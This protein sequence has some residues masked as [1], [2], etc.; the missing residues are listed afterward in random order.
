MHR[1]IKPANLLFDEEGRVRVADFG[2]ARALAEA[3]WTEPAGA[4]VGTARYISPEAAEGK[5]VDGR[6]DV[7]SLALVLY[8]AVT[9]T[10]PFVT[11]TTMGTLAARIGQP[12]PHD[13]ALGPLDDV[14]ARAAA[15]AAAA[16][17]D[18]S[19]LGARLGALA[20]ALPTAAP[21]PLIIGNHD[22]SSPIA[23]FRAP[24]VSELTEVVPV[25]GA[26]AGAAAGAAGGAHGTMVSGT[27]PEAGPRA[28]PGA[29]TGAGAVGG[30]ASDAHAP[31]GTK[32]G[33]G[34]I[35]DAE[36]SGTRATVGAKPVGGAPVAVRPRRRRR[37]LWIVAA[38]VAVA[39][40]VIVAAGL[41]V[42]FKNNVFTPSHPAPSLVGLPVAQA[43]ALAA[44]DHFTVHQA[45]GA[46]SI[47]VP[48]GSVIT[49]SPAK[50]TSLK[51]GSTMTVV[52]SLGLPDVTVPSLSG[53]TCAEATATLETARLKAVCAPARY[54]NSVPAGQLVLWSIG[55]TANPTT[56]PYGSQIT[57]DPS[58]GHS[59]A[60]V[61]PIPT[62]YSFAQAQ[63]ALQAVGLTATQNSHPSA[64][65]PAGQ[66]I[67][68]TPASGAMAPYGSAV[69]VTVS[70][71]P[72]TT[73]VP[74]VI[75]DTVAQAT[76]VIE[77]AGL[78]VS[79]VSGNPSHMVMGTGPSV[80]STV[81][82]G[83]SVQLLTR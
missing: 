75:G 35:F 48:A 17:L 56:A 49:Q 58:A 20:S 14:L 18:A 25:A 63:A 13:P 15:P 33:P 69:A 81:D 51:E 47:T 28:G 71:G 78:S 55:A 38:A 16:R 31:V 41:F 22:S 82:I 68:T 53:M 44:R 9:G 6:A 65:V 64:T 29:A 8:E 74:N 10:V 77:A 3:A 42:A 43:Q 34:E 1:D 4:M 70:S 45:T 61:P 36:P 11:D 83:S 50:G 30:D 67:S 21:L 7:Y 2:V 40:A 27:G 72:P 32:A 66:V 46:K 26:G 79:G 24:G 37:T 76:S 57:L 54:D 80:G 19:G 12:L 73:T 5:H 60:Q 39:V 59:P 23:G 62:T 52:P